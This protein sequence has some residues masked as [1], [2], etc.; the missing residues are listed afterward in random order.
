V[1]KSLREQLKELNIEFPKRVEI[2]K[3]R[4]LSAKKQ[5]QANKRKARE[6]Q[7][8][9]FLREARILQQFDEFAKKPF[10]T[11]QRQI[12]KPWHKSGSGIPTKNEIKTGK[13]FWRKPSLEEAKTT[14]EK[15]FRTTE[16]KIL[17]RRK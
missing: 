5:R 1:E 7:A 14:S 3:E 2:Q 9:R 17:M 8:E 16:E 15:D 11:H 4:I 12:T 10:P 13:E 6:K